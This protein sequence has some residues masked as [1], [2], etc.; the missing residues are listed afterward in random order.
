MNLWKGGGGDPKICCRILGFPGKAQHS[1]PKQGRGGGPFG[2]FPN[3]S[4][5]GH[6][7]IPKYENKLTRDRASICSMQDF[8]I[9]VVN[10]CDNE[11]TI[12]LL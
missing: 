8:L 4:N 7:I 9:K 3:S 2:V 12:C 10:I 11:V 1:F 6:P 5:F